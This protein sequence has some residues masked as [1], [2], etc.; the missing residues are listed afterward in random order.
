MTSGIPER[1]PLTPFL[2]SVKSHTGQ[3]QQRCLLVTVVLVFF[4]DLNSGQWR[5]CR[6]A[7]GLP[8]RERDRERQRETERDR[9]IE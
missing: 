2:Q 1:F 6:G 9:E 5:Q 8:E 4:S 3:E 7:L